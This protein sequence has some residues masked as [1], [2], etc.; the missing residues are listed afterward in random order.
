MNQDDRRR[1][2]ELLGR[3]GFCADMGLHDDWLA[4]WTQDGVYDIV[5]SPAT[6]AY[7]GKRRVF[8]GQAG[9]REL[10]EDTDWS[11]EYRGPQ[12]SSVGNRPARRD[13]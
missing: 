10:I 9:L 6:R 8:A 2:A 11:H 13:P 3:Y 5:A 12:R 1:L 7:G 4:L